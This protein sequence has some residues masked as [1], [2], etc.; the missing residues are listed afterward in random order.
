[1]DSCPSS[2]PESNNVSSDSIFPCPSV[3]RIMGIFYQIKKKN[4]SGGQKYYR[5][6]EEKRKLVLIYL[7]NNLS[8]P[9]IERL[10]K[11]VLATIICNECNII[12]FSKNNLDYFPSKKKI[13]PWNY[14]DDN[15][16]P[17]ETRMF[18]LCR[19]MQNIQIL[20]GSGG[21]CKYCCKYVGK[22]DKHNYC[23]VFTSTDGSLIR[24][25]DF[26]QNTKR[27]TSDKVKQV[28]QEKKR[29]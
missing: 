12:V 26:L 29:N 10:E 14:G 19:S 9:C 7:R 25:A 4:W 5:K 1:M 8:K 27:V 6:S 15:I 23:T 18:T 2:P 20:S 24:C 22:I 28:E 21:S 16:S 11:L 3:V 17:C 13:P